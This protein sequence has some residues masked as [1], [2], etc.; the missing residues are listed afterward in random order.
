MPDGRMSTSKSYCEIVENRRC[1]CGHLWKIQSASG[2]YQRNHNLHS[3]GE[4]SESGVLKMETG[5]SELSLTSQ[6]E[7]PSVH[8]YQ[9]GA[10]YVKPLWLLHDEPWRLLFSGAGS[11]SCVQSAR[12]QGKLDMLSSPGC[13]SRGLT[14]RAFR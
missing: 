1:H 4:N 14:T 13:E 6:S 8:I 11:E 10:I 12:G 7:K 9:F 5:W 2:I 3:R